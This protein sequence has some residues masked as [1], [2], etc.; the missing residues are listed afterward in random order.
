MVV[1]WSSP[2]VL[3]KNSLRHN[4]WKFQP[5][6]PLWTKRWRWTQSVYDDVWKVELLQNYLAP[7]ILSFL[8]EKKT[9]YFPWEEKKCPK[10]GKHCNF[11][12]FLHQLPFFLCAPTSPSFCRLQELLSHFN[13]AFHLSL[14]SIRPEKKKRKSWIIDKTVFYCL[15][16]HRCHLT[17]A[18]HCNHCALHGCVAPGLWF[19]HL[20]WGRALLAGGT[21][22]SRRRQWSWR[23]LV[24]AIIWKFWIDWQ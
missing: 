22:C 21:Q 15:L 2:T 6:W 23:H 16:I 18:V 11:T 3:H 9:S 20:S 17:A 19:W 13:P 14:L 24:F 10:F 12:S 7:V 4:I 8:G 5:P 1:T